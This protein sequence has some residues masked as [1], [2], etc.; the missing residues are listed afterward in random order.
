MMS[1]CGRP[2]SP[3]PTPPFGGSSPIASRISIDD[4][5]LP[6]RV[7]LETKPAPA[8]VCETATEHPKT[9]V[10]GIARALSRVLGSFIKFHSPCALLSCGQWDADLIP[11]GQRIF[12]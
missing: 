7:A 11:A 3:S 6:L 5:S 12:M 4:V 9:I 1:P 10:N 8:F 2:L